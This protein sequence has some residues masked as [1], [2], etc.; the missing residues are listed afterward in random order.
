ML[1]ALKVI[2][3]K[4]N[5]GIEA[6]ILN[7][8]ARLMSLKVPDIYKIQGNIVLG[9]EDPK[10]YLTADEKYYG[11]T[12]G[13]S[14][15]RIAKG[16]CLIKDHVYNLSINNPPNHLHGGNNGFHNQIWTIKKETVNSV[17]LE[18]LSKDQEE[19]YPGNVRIEVIY[20]LTDLGL[21]I[22]YLGTTDQ[23][24]ILNLTHH[25]YF[26]LTGNTSTSIENH[27]LKIN[28]EYFTPINEHLVPT[29]E[30]KSVVGTPFDFRTQRYIGQQINASNQQIKYGSGYD[31]NFVL[32]QKNSRKI[33]LAAEVFE[34][35]SGR[36][37]QVWTNQPGLHLYTGNHLS[38]KDISYKNKKIDKRSGFCLETQHFPDTPNHELFPISTLL[39]NEIYEYSCEYRFPYL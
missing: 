23:A 6:Q 2:S 4:N 28:A 36:L 8:G 30:I 22:S 13:R 15:N 19:G 7:Y 31:H 16:K 34:P 32:K 27:I 29:G 11:A 14:T 38:G 25:S 12:I 5:T 18:Y 39:P 33:I 24:T 35:V 21:K 37:M 20:E 1:N 9:F 26:N 3:L 10:K 17:H